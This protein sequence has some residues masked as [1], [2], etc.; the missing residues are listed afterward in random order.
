M[1]EELVASFTSL[2]RPFRN[3]SH[4]TLTSVA[5]ANFIVGNLRT[6]FEAISAILAG[7][8]I[9]DEFDVGVALAAIVRH[10]Y[11]SAVD[12]LELAASKDIPLAPEIWSSVLKEALLVQDYKL[13]DTILQRAHQDDM[14]RIDPH[15][16]DI[17]VRHGHD[18]ARATRQETQRF[19]EISLRLLTASRGP[20]ETAWPSLSTICIQRAISAKLP[21]LAFRFWDRFCR[22]HRSSERSSPSTLILPPGKLENSIALALS[23]AHRSGDASFSRT[24]GYGMCRKLGAVKKW[25]PLKAAKEPLNMT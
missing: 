8:T 22:P 5:S 7:K 21:L 17:V 6:G 11:A 12:V 10:D 18:Y 25:R 4:H 3:A 1:A 2:N 13:V 20:G 15:L 9:P 16:V 19:L 24:Q 23:N 14:L